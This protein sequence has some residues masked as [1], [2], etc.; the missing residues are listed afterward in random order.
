MFPFFLTRIIFLTDLYQNN[1]YLSV[2]SSALI[3]FNLLYFLCTQ[4]Y[5][6]SIKTRKMLSQLVLTTFPPKNILKFF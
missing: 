5:A 3:N 4:L 1:Y 6:I 2:I